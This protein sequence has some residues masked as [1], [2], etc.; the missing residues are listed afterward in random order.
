LHFHLYKK[1]YHSCPEIGMNQ[2]A[3]GRNCIREEY[4]HKVP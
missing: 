4:H 2:Q 3:Y 1:E